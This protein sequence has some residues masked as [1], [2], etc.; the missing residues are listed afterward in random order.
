MLKLIKIIISVCLL[1]TLVGSIAFADDLMNPTNFD[2]KDRGQH[3]DALG[4]STSLRIALKSLND[5]QL[6]NTPYGYVEGGKT[7]AT[8]QGTVTDPE[9][10]NTSRDNIGTSARLREMLSYKLSSL[11][12]IE[13]IERDNVNSIVRELEFAENNKYVKKETLNEVGLEMPQFFI[14]AF[15]TVNEGPC[16]EDDS[17]EE[18]AWGNDDELKRPKKP[19]RLMLRFYDIKT[20]KVVYITC[21]SGVIIKD[22][23]D[24]SVDDFKKHKYLFYPEM[25]VRS[26]SGGIVNIDH[27]KK[28]GM[29][30][31]VR[32]LLVRHSGPLKSLKMDD[33]PEVV[34]LCEVQNSDSH[35]CKAEIIEKYEGYAPEKGD[36][37]VFSHPVVRE[38]D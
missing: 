1:L 6:V 32:F 8:K 20:S 35:G 10:Y 2:H 19:Y 14:K 7:V 4:P 17:A 37:V 16:R 33:N 38:W 34:A 24:R 25:R 30:A 28:S 27:G 36:L 13:L 12:F 22:A 18:E 9:R 29:T 5:N 23:I 15:F 26:V 21:G 3:L 11:P 31:G